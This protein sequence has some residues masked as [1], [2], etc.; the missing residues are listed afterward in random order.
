MLLEKKSKL[1]SDSVTTVIMGLVRNKPLGTLLA[2]S[3]FK[4]E[5]RACA[6]RFHIRHG[7]LKLFRHVWYGDTSFL[8]TESL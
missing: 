3:R 8:V 1:H 4:R 5:N 2:K 6:A 7:L